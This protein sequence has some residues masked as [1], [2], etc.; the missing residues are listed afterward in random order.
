MPYLSALIPISGNYGRSTIP[1]LFEFRVSDSDHYHVLEQSSP[2]L[3][4]DRV[5]LALSLFFAFYFLMH[6]INRNRSI[7]LQRPL[8]MSGNSGS[9]RVMSI[10]PIRL[11]FCQ[12]SERLEPHEVS[13]SVGGPLGRSTVANG[14][15]PQN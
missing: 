14:G 6:T 3:V 2:F 1:L 4:P 12:S 9:C 7:H 11:Y 8:T 13:K 5:F 15:F 10:F